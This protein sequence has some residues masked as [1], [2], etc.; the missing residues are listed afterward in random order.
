MEDKGLL[1]NIDYFKTNSE[2]FINFAFLQFV[3]LL[4]NPF[5]EKISNN[6]YTYPGDYNSFFNNLKVGCKFE[7]EANEGYLKLLFNNINSDNNDFDT[8]IYSKLI[9][10]GKE[11][12]LNPK[13]DIYNPK[14]KKIK[15]SIKT[16][17]EIHRNVKVGRTCSSC[18]I[19]FDDKGIKRDPILNSLINLYLNNKSDNQRSFNEKIN[20]FVT[21]ISYPPKKVINND[22]SLFEIDEEKNNRIKYENFQ[23]GE[24]YF[25]QGPP[26]TGKTYTINRLI[27]ENND[28]KKFDKIIVSSYVHVAINN[29]IDHMLGKNIPIDKYHP[30]YDFYQY[31][32]VLYS[33]R[34]L[35]KLEDS[36]SSKLIE[37]D[38]LLDEELYDTA[39]EIY[40][41]RKDKSK[42][43]INDFDKKLDSLN[44]GNFKFNVSNSINNRIKQITGEKFKRIFTILNN[45]GEDYIDYEKAFEL[46][47]ELSD[48]YNKDFVYGKDKEWGVANYSLSI[49]NYS[50]IIFCTLNNLQRELDRQK[51]SDNILVI[52]DEASKSNIINY[53]L[54]L[55]NIDNITLIVL[56]DPE[57][58]NEPL[59]FSNNVN[60]YS[61]IMTAFTF[62][63]L[64]DTFIKDNYNKYIIDDMK[65]VLF[66]LI[67][68]KNNRANLS[69]QVGFE[70]YS[71]INVKLWNDILSEKFYE[72]LF[73]SASDKR[74]QLL[75][76]HRRS[77][78][79]I[80][81]LSKFL[82]PDSYIM[83][84]KNIDD[85]LLIPNY[86]VLTRIVIDK[87]DDSTTTINKIIKD[88]K[89]KQTKIN[90]N[91]T[92]GIITFYNDYKRQFEKEIKEINKTNIS[93]YT[94]D[95]SQGEE[96]TTVIIYLDVDPIN[97]KITSFA[98][99]YHRI[100]V[101]VSRA[102]EQLIIVE[103]KEFIDEY[104]K[105]KSSIMDSKYKTFIDKIHS[106]PERGGSHE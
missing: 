11:I 20:T 90:K 56:G 60:D 16:L 31:M 49:K 47:N 41:L 103:T 59:V 12:N 40:S 13:E 71:D 32:T 85:D 94:V 36:P 68:N 81:E 2:L 62:S 104:N 102:K 105:A 96:F 91:M 84:E 43:L 28:N 14:N 82:Y 79:E 15:L 18:E 44:Q 29:I 73:N 80:F 10:L 55:N 92:M 70:K 7:E 57:Q 5:L 100:N 95:S 6:I 69:Q 78:K 77:R 72:T 66:E 37:L 99:D 52:I 39:Y 30:F 67:K 106:I 65:K 27:K 97:R 9:I 3:K 98:K 75:N 33:N 25:F 1:K 101:A 74:K 53:L 42:E 26:G 51:N 63:N 45:S 35:S 21:K 24:I 61:K 48:K 4:G 22:D 86:D 38:K 17:N 64:K 88:W 23:K 83:G 58:L 19:Y 54:L 87:Q 46:I 34:A 76:I 93:L 89:I 50:N 8:Y